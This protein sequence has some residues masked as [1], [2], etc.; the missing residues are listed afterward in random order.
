ML[1]DS[2]PATV[3]LSIK[4]IP[5]WASIDW[6]CNTKPQCVLA[7]PGYRA[8]A[9]RGGARSRNRC[10]HRT[11][12]SS[13]TPRSIRRHHRIPSSSESAS[14]ARA[15]RPFSSIASFR[16]MWMATIPAWLPELRPSSQWEELPHEMRAD[17]AMAAAKPSK[18]GGG[19]LDDHTH[20]CTPPTEANRL[21]KRVLR[22]A[23]LLV[24]ENELSSRVPQ[25]T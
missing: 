17:D 15:E 23:C 20:P 8:R 11:L 25:A 10:Q 3:D 24:N 19:E 4:F 1:A 16:A 14:W 21:Q 5:D 13:R 9:Q 22:S 18:Q 7:C 6:R 2:R 12:R